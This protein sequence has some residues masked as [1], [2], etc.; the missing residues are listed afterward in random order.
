MYAGGQFPETN[1][2]WPAERV[3]PNLYKSDFSAIAD[4]TRGS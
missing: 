3:S 4:W 1:R 2:L